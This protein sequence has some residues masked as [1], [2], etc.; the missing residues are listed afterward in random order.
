MTRV[1]VLWPQLASYTSAC[2]R[3]LQAEGA[4]VHV[5][6]RRA[7]PDAPYDDDELNAGLSA[8]SWQD[9]VDDDTVERTIAR[10]RPDVILAASWNVG[11]YRRRLRARRGQVLRIVFMDNAWLA[12][13]KQWAGRL[14]R[15]AIISP[16]FDA[17]FVSGERQATFARHLGF[18]TDRILWG[19]YACAETFFTGPREDAP[20][21]FGFVGR[22]ADEKGVDVLAA[23]YRSYAATEA[24]AWPLVVAGV[25]PRRALLEDLP[26]VEMAGFVR[27]ADLPALLERF[28]CLVLPSTFEPWG[29]VVQEA[30]A[31]GL[32]V[33][34]TDACGASTRL[35]LDGYN[36]RVVPAGD[37]VALA[38]AL[39]WV[40]GLPDER[41][42]ELSRASVG[43]AAQYTPA[44]WARYFLDRCAE[45]TP[46]VRR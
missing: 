26:G 40:A 25:G 14:A 15:R 37:P 20:R 42:A 16:T 9:S 32:P 2:F 10:V 18:P 3:A 43:L 8:E 13:P 28:G 30:A 38:G 23:A 35:V 45:L 22:L 34:C 5:L 29:V 31:S 36:G 1:L 39:R 12:T 7:T 17:A 41:R 33:V 24:E 19:N 46:L 27:P 21:T 6:H 4:D 11:A 44:R